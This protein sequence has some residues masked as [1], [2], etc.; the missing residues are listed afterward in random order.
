[1]VNSDIAARALIMTVLKAL[2]E[3]KDIAPPT[4]ERIRKLALKWLRRICRRN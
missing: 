2:R 4:R 3:G 1:M